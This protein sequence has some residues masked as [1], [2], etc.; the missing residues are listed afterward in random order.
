MSLFSKQ[1][2]N[3]LMFGLQFST[4][5]VCLCQAVFVLRFLGGFSSSGFEIIIPFQVNFDYNASP[6]SLSRTSAYE[7]SQCCSLLSCSCYRNFLFCGKCLVTQSKK[8]GFIGLLKQ[9][10]KLLSLPASCDLS[11]YSS[12]VTW[13]CCTDVF[14]AF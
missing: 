5:H 10:L 13:T 6:L 3:I 9:Q 14:L 4:F 7:N 1:K 2:A 12:L 8:A 11:S